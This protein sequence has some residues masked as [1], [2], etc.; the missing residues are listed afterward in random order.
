MYNH[1]P[2]NFHRYTTDQPAISSR[3]NVKDKMIRS[4]SA[5]ATVTVVVAAPPPQVIVIVVVVVE[6]VVVP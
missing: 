4:I 2:R 6:V 3:L 5:R 1:H